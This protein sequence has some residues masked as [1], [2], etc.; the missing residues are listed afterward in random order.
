MQI[1]I[2]ELLYFPFDKHAVCGFV[3]HEE[4]CLLPVCAEGPCRYEFGVDH[5]T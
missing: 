2:Q 1:M 3:Q 5:V 4:E